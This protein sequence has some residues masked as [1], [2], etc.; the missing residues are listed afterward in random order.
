MKFRKVRLSAIS[1]SASSS[2]ARPIFPPIPQHTSPS[3]TVSAPRTLACVTPF[4]IA[5]RPGTSDDPL[6]VHHPFDGHTV[7]TTSYA[8][9]EQVER[10]VAA[11]A[12]VAAEAAALPASAR[13]AALDLVSHT[14][15]RRAADVA[16]LI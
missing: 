3:T 5:G 14:L 9:E 15:A 11:A 16:D 1:R 2:A 8:T 4:Y 6:P 10:A 7:G 13:A 12:A